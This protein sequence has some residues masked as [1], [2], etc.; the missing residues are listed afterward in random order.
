MSQARREVPTE[1]A[2]GAAIES[3]GKRKCSERS[4]DTVTLCEPRPDTPPHSTRRQHAPPAHRGPPVTPAPRC[5]GARGGPGGAGPGASIQGSQG[6][7]VCPQESPPQLPKSLASAPASIAHLL[8]P[9]DPFPPP[10]VGEGCQERPLGA[11]QVT[12]WRPAGGR[13]VRKRGSL[14]GRSPNPVRLTY[15]R[16][17]G[18]VKEVFTEHLQ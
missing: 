5:A 8:Q 11:D 7:P 12:L 18:S 10:G 9:P 15:S 14:Q 1:G 2:F 16:T 17:A 3:R 6:S 4:F 13:G